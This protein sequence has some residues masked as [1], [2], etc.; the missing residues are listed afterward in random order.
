MISACHPPILSEL[1][2]FH[3]M[4]LYD[5]IMRTIIELP[6]SQVKDLSALCRKEGISRA[7]AIRR[8]VTMMLKYQKPLDG[9]LAKAFGMWKDRANE[10]RRMRDQLRGEWR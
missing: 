5:D 1:D 3:Q 6:E 9:G 7:E 2:S 4:T 10:V 8:A